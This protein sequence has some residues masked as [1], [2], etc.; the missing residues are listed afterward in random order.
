MSYT[1]NKTFPSSSASSFIITKGQLVKIGSVLDID[2][3]SSDYGIIIEYLY[4]FGASAKEEWLVL[5]KGKLE[6]I[7]CNM[8]WPIGDLNEV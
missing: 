5:I 4:G 8:I 6:R 7:Q 2:K 3:N 1:I